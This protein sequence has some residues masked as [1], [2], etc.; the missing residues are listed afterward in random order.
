MEDAEERSIPL[1]QGSES[2]TSTQRDS[3][4]VFGKKLPKTEIVFFAQITAIYIILITSIV[5]ISLGSESELWV[6]LLSTSLG[7]VLPQPDLKPIKHH[8]IEREAHSSV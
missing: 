7:A 6:I 5:N 1:V 4:D 3:W 2:R 8:G